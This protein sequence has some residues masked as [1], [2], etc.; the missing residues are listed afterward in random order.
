MTRM[1]GIGI[2]ALWLAAALTPLGAQVSTL[3]EISLAG[4]SLSSALGSAVGG[5]GPE[6]VAFDGT[7]IWT[8]EQ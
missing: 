8:A 5:G 6:A 7:N 1:A 3:H 4:N 2:F